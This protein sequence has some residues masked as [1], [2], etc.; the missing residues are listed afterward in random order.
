MRRIFII[1]IIIIFCACCF[2][3]CRDYVS[4]QFDLSEEKIYW[5]GSIDDNFKDDRVCIIFKR[6]DTYPQ[7]KISDF[8]FS[9]GARIEYDDLRPHNM[10]DA[11]YLARYRQ[12]ATIYLKDTG[13]DKVV[14]AV[15]YLQTLDFIKC[16]EP[17]MIF[18]PMD[19]VAVSG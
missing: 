1:A 7:L 5:K 16:V 18:E 9:N 11:N 14:E 3:G 10:T 8:K 2:V 12:M 17:D 15:E 19:D 4:K 6:T 13:K